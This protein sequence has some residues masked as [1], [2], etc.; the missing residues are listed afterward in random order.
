[1]PEVGHRTSASIAHGGEGSPS[2]RG[3]DQGMPADRGGVETGKSGNIPERGGYDSASPT[4]PTLAHRIG[5]DAPELKHMP[6]GDPRPTPAA[7][8]NGVH[9]GSNIPKGA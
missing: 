3:G 9:R 5:E 7:A 6:T 4:A 1:M 2:N 8:T